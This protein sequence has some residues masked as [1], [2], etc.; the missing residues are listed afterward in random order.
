MW[1]MCLSKHASY[2]ALAAASS[3][4]EQQQQQRQ[5]GAASGGEGGLQGAPSEGLNAACDSPMMPGELS[6][7]L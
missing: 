5:G 4:A 3:N 6:V 2:K 7:N 1:R